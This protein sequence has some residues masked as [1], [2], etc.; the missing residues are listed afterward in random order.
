LPIRE[1]SVIFV[2]ETLLM[3]RLFILLFV[4]TESRI[5]TTQHRL[6]EDRVV[7]IGDK[8]IPLVAPEPAVLS[9]KT[10][11]LIN[12]FI[13]GCLKIP[14]LMSLKDFRSKE[15][16]EEAVAAAPVTTSKPLG[17]IAVFFPG[18]GNWGPSAAWVFRL[19][20]YAER[21]VIAYEGTS[22]PDL[23]T[24][25]VAT[26]IDGIEVPEDLAGKIFT[27]GDGQNRAMISPDQGADLM[28]KYYSIMKE[29]QELFN[30]GDNFDLIEGETTLIG[31][32]EGPFCI[33]L[34]RERLIAAGLDK[35]IGKI[36]TLGGGFGD[37][38]QVPNSAGLATLYTWLDELDKFS[39]SGDPDVAAYLTFVQ[40]I[41][42]GKWKGSDHVQNIDLG[43]A[44]IIG[45]PVEFH[46]LPPS[47]SGQNNIR[48]QF[49][50]SAAG[51]KF[52]DFI[53]TPLKSL[54]DFVKSGA[55][56]AD[57]ETDGIMPKELALAGKATY[58]IK[59]PHD[60]AGQIEDYETLDEWVVTSF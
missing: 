10:Q 51:L 60:H 15:F 8:Q 22:K 25:I 18:F 13:A 12:A 49:R 27:M 29:K 42:D 17:K 37:I 28:I 14:P 54:L 16:A 4:V 11:D 52:I 3:F 24:L 9:K 23:N 45:P 58:L 41:I 2:I 1:N 39:G 44:S 48:P 21:V 50:L 56:S 35:I 19:A 30:L 32:S 57:T 7:T 36:V 26:N 43:I 55:G 59:I 5:L 40:N 34:A 33:V 46:I 47:I 6:S 38:T 53:E 20:Q 31:H